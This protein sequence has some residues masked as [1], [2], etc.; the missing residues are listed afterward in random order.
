MSQEIN[1]SNNLE[2]ET[3]KLGEGRVI[4][5]KGIGRKSSEKVMDVFKE[6]EKSRQ[7]IYSNLEKKKSV[8]GGSQNH[9]ESAIRFIKS[10][11]DFIVHSNKKN[12]INLQKSKQANQS[13]QAIAKKSAIEMFNS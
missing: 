8:F 10:V 7:L 6:A 12:E 13:K 2:G 9:E 1:K 3:E 4:D 5:D 11:T